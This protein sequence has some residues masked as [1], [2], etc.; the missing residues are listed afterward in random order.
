MRRNS[1]GAISLLFIISLG[2]P[3]EALAVVVLKV[4]AKQPIMGHLVRQDER[5]VVVREE[6]PGGDSRE[7]QIPRSQIDEL[8]LTVSPQR[9]A[10]LDPAQPQVYREY[11]EELAEKRRDPEARDA[12]RRLYAI[13]AA[14]GGERLRRGALLGLV[15]LARSPAE[16][17]RLRAAAFL[18]DPAHDPA[19]LA[20]P[21]PA[22]PLTAP[23]APPPAELAAAV[24]LIRQGRG[25][26][27]AA[28]LQLPQVRRAARTLASALTLAEL[29]AAASAATLGDEQLAKILRA[30]LLL[31]GTAA[32]PSRTEKQ[33]AWSQTIQSGDLVPLPS[34][35]LDKLTEFDPAECL[36][37]GG[38]W[39]RP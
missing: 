11:A 16:E 38:K 36:F 33:P 13:A 32:P 28:L 5:I 22:S 25:A 14:R 12:A 2:V 21:T 8:I 1:S 6:V 26:E 3:A 31:E 30:E 17:R 7:T 29:D 18:H 35:S 39:V 15:A 23:T 10:A 37:R 19:I 20:S 34:L 27:A 9:L 4:G 24:R